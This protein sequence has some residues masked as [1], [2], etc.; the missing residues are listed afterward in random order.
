MPAARSV[1]R[2]RVSL[3]IVLDDV[4]RA[5]GGLVRILS[6]G[7]PGAPLAKEIPAL[8]ERDFDPRRRAWSS[9]DSACAAWERSRRCSS[10]A[11]SLI[12]RTSSA[13]SMAVSSRRSQE[14]ELDEK[15]DYLKWR[16]SL[17]TGCPDRCGGIPPSVRLRDD[18]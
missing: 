18:A 13:S 3:L 12:R 9:S 4:G 1:F 7:P 8:V 10:S 6:D 2:C 5:D 15:H 17:R 16:S 11:S 14:R